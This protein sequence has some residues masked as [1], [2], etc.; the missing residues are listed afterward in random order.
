MES[1]PVKW[2]VDDN[3]LRTYRT[4]QITD[5]IRD[6]GYELHQVTWDPLS[7]LDPIPFSADDCVVLYGTH[8]FVRAVQKQYQFQ[9]GALGVTDRTCVAQY[10]SNLPLDWFL[11]R[12]AIM[13]TWGIF[14]QRRED[15]F[16]MFGGKQDRV[17]VRPNSGFKTFAGQCIRWSHIDHDIATID[18]LSS[19]MDDTLI[20]VNGDLEIK[21][22][23][24]FVIADGKV[25]A[26][27][28]Y[29][30]D[31]ILDIRSDYP[32]ECRQFAEKVAQ[33][34][35]QVD[36]AYTC[37]VALTLDGPKLVELN[38]FSCAGLYACDLEA[39]VHGISSTAWREWSGDDVQ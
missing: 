18:K 26:G 4:R 27:S 23:F 15:W 11:N 32:E 7:P 2:V 31:G 37:D 33:H 38:G 12:D 39:V 17:F 30:W 36:I 16:F 14:K 10:M 21:G 22:E 34:P 19:A 35:W 1:K 3:I 25:I 13:T 8:Q 29:R 20:L 28:E 5:V 9:P 6:L 24:R